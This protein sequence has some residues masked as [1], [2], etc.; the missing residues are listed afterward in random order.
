VEITFCRER[1][2]LNLV[3]F[4]EFVDSSTTET[5]IQ[6]ETDS[7][8]RLVCEGRI[9]STEVKFAEYTAGF[10]TD[11]GCKAALC[12]QEY[13]GVAVGSECDLIGRAGPS[14]L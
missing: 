2:V 5:L 1:I 9:P 4:W 12:E 14:L 10:S 3:A 11:S 7:L 8:T 6:I 13:D